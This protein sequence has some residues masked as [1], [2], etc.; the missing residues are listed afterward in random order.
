MNLVD[1]IS[2]AWGWIGIDPVEVVAENDFGNLIVRDVDGKFWRLCP[3]D[4]YC[5]VIAADR[6]S[7][8]ALATDQQF[9]QDWSMRD[10]VSLA[11]DKLGPLPEGK[12]YCLKIPGVLGGAYGGDN[13]ATISLLELVQSSG[14]IAKEIQDIPDGVKVRLKVV[15]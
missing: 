9:L 2:S 10:L 13:L 7:L 1:E 15:E 8:D 5:T 14:H 4:C 6:Q 12:K 11:Q 3:E